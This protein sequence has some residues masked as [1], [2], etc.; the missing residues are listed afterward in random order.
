MFTIS[1]KNILN[2]TDKSIFLSFIFIFS[3]LL[4]G[5]LIYM[6]INENVRPGIL[7]LFLRFYTDFSNKTYIEI[8]SG[9]ALFGIFYFI[10]MFISGSSFYGKT[11]SALVTFVKSTGLTLLVSYLYCE[12]SLM[13]LE[14][15]LLV[16]FPG[17][18]VLISGM[19]LMTKNCIDM[20][21]KLIKC[22][23]TD[24]NDYKK[25]YLIKSILALF[26]II[27]SCLVDLICI[28]I[29]S[30]LFNNIQQ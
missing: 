17:K 4:S 2:K 29:F 9:I 5:V 3:G 8:F 23:K 13:G 20:S 28:K 27:F 14:Y 15:V 11:I 18:T 10:I 22:N 30:P 21:D 1:L 24:F 25:R 19:L 16:F 12:F 6:F 26:I 7:K